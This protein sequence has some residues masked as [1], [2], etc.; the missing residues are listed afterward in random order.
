MSTVV[1]DIDAALESARSATGDTATPATV[2]TSERTKALLSQLSQLSQR[3]N[4]SASTL[5]GL[6][7]TVVATVAARPSPGDLTHGCSVCGQPARFGLRVRLEEG[8]EG[9][10]F[11]A[12]HRPQEAGTS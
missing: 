9:R 2:A 10:L 1:F 11:C 12:A 4:L 7:V 6:N 3:A 5:H 8:K